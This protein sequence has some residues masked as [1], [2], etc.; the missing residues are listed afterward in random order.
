MR[1]ILSDKEV[2]P[3]AMSYKKLWKLLIDRDLS[4]KDLKEL[5]GVSN[6]SLTKMRK[7]GNVTTDVL[8][9]IC[10]ALKCNTDDIME[11]VPDKAEEE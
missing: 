5:S 7:G 3:M 2:A 1:R 10:K 4:N 6:A 8:L 9:K 11:V